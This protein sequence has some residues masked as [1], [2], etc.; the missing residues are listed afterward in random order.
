MDCKLRLFNFA[1]LRIAFG[2]HK[3]YSHSGGHCPFFVALL[4]FAVVC[5]HMFPL[6]PVALWSSHFV[7]CPTITVGGAVAHGLGGNPWP[8]ALPKNK[9][10]N[11]KK[12]RERDFQQARPPRETFLTGL[13]Q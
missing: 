10:K 2:T 9:K 7:P 3:D 1:R 11:K 4:Q 8:T 13:K 6:L 12:K 5:T